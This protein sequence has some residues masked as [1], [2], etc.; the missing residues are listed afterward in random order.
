[1][2]DWLN[3]THV[4]PNSEKFREKLDFRNLENITPTA[5]LDWSFFEGLLPSDISDIIKL[6]KVSL[7][8]KRSRKHKDKL[9]YIFLVF[10]TYFSCRTIAKAP[11]PELKKNRSFQILT[12][13]RNQILRPKL[14]QIFFNVLILARF[15]VSRG[16]RV[17]G[18]RPV[19][20]KHI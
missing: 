1:M 16:Y 9:I 5:G 20:G 18:L 15:S 6:G 17:F 4:E 3:P 2:D 13:R 7:N 14:K 11:T 10:N 19:P 12:Y 8:E